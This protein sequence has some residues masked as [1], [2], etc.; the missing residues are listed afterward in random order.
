MVEMNQ[1]KALKPS[2][3]TG[4]SGPGAIRKKGPEKLPNPCAL[5]LADG[6]HI[7]RRDPLNGNHT[8]ELQQL[9]PIPRWAAWSLQT[10]VPGQGSNVRAKNGVLKSHLPTARKTLFL[11]MF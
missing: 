5:W 6:L 9:E 1:A 3:Y 10:T 11:K 2:E 4:R 7:P 8:E